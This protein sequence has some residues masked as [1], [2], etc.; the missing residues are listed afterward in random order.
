MVQVL[1]SDITIDKV[2]MF[3]SFYFVTKKPQYLLSPSLCDIW[4][5]CIIF[6]E[7]TIQKQLSWYTTTSVIFTVVFLAVILWHENS[8]MLL[9][10]A[11]YIWLKY[12]KV[13]YSSITMQW[14]YQDKW[15]VKIPELWKITSG[16]LIVRFRITR[17]FTAKARFIF[18]R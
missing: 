15:S 8:P 10:S 18:P 14:S 6:W 7:F 9:T 1:I 17:T 16:P 5:L 3:S 13:C 2:S 12:I 4:H 11:I